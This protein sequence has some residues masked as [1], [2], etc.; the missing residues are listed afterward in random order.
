MTGDCHVRFR[1]GLGV[2]F[3]RA[4]RHLKIRELKK[5]RIF[6]TFIEYKKIERVWI[7]HFLMLLTPPDIK[8][9]FG[10]DGSRLTPL[11]SQIRRNFLITIYKKGKGEI[12]FLV[13]RVP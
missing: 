7:I 10:L 11:S 4:T 2:K 1:E 13:S 12:D 3:L 8:V 6:K 9:F 5:V